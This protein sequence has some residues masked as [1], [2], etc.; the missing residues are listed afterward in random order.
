MCF[1]GRLCEVGQFAITNGAMVPVH[2]PMI[3]QVLGAGQKETLRAIRP[4]KVRRIAALLAEIAGSGDGQKAGRVW[5]ESFLAEAGT[6][7]DIGATIT[8]IEPDGTRHE[9]VPLSLVESRPSLAGGQVIADPESSGLA[10][11]IDRRLEN[12]MHDEA[13]S[14]GRSQTSAANMKPQPG[15]CSHDRCCNRLTLTPQPACRDAVT[16]SGQPA[17]KG[18][19]YP[20]RI[21]EGCIRHF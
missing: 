21:A 18:A 16:D 13:K 2:G 14:S 10:L 4:N 1:A 5:P 9:R 3:E 11:Q 20:E 7:R 8:I 12:I 17:W 15:L 6:L 19:L